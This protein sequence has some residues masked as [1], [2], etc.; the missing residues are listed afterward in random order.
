MY[1]SCGLVIRGPKGTADNNIRYRT[2]LKFVYKIY[3][4]IKT[5]RIYY[6]L[7]ILLRFAAYYDSLC[8]IIQE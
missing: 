3:I 4:Y 8:L 5:R 7:V 6:Y 1:S 2:L